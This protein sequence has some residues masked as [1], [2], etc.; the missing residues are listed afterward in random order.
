MLKKVL[1]VGLIVLVPKLIDELYEGGKTLLFGEDNLNEKRKIDRSVVT[2]VMREWIVREYSVYKETG[3][4]SDGT[5]IENIDALVQ[6]LNSELSINK[7]RSTYTRMWRT[8]N[9]D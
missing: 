9:N 7:S 1:E 3:I 4:L 6:Y 2:P 5:K 8:Q